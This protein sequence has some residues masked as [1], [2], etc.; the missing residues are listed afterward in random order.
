MST[1]PGNQ[2]RRAAGWYLDP[3]GRPVLRWWDGRRWTEH[4]RAA[5]R[6]LLSTYFGDLPVPR[7]SGDSLARHSRGEEPSVPEAGE[8]RR[9]DRAASPDPVAVNRLR[10]NLVESSNGLSP[11]AQVRRRHASG[12]GMTQRSIS[13]DPEALPG[14]NEALRRELTTVGLSAAFSA[15]LAVIAAGYLLNVGALRLAGVLGAVFF[16]V[17]AAPLQLSERSTLATRLGVAGIVGLSTVTVAGSVMVLGPGWH[18]LRAAVIIGLAAAAV[19]VQ[20]LRRA[21]PA[22]RGSG[23]FGSL[24]LRWGGMLG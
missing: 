12:A 21:L 1:T 5:P 13:R 6:E 22:L 3:Q 8:R 10:D 20:A 15:A 17:G 4:T 19:H 2:V 14:G 18:P 9:H 16:G 24:G 23:G 7:R 11:P